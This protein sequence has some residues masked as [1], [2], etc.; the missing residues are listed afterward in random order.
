MKIISASR[1]E[2]MPRFHF[3]ELLDKYIKYEN[4]ARHFWVFWT[5]NPENLVRSGFDFQRAFLQ[6]TITGLGSSNLEP[7]V[8]APKE[9][10]S[11]LERIIDKGFSPAHINWRLDPLIPGYNVKGDLIKSLA[12]QISSLGITRCT[13]S[14]I[15]WYGHVKE[16]WPEGAET[17]RTVMQQRNIASTV[18]QILKQYGI[19]LYGCAQPALKGIV[20]PA[21][22]IDAELYQNL[23][24]IDFEN[25]KDLSQRKACGCTVSQDIGKYRTCPHKCLYCYN[26]QT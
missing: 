1:R 3:K 20:T 12:G 11:V 5:K 18:A 23:T 6:V 9:I 8:P 4:E 21:K 7:N 19:T 13:T 25:R 14:F 22:C 10:I 16:R 24:G 17:Q 2:D 15:T 26:K